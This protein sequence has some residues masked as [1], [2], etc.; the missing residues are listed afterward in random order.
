MAHTK[1]TTKKLTGGKDPRKTPTQQRRDE[2]Q[3]RWDVAPK[4]KDRKDVNE[5][6]THKS[7][8]HKERK[9]IRWT[10]EFS[11]IRFNITQ[12]TVED[13]EIRQQRLLN[14]GSDGMS[15]VLKRKWQKCIT[16]M[17]IN[18]DYYRLH[19]TDLALQNSYEITAI[20]NSRMEQNHM[21]API[22]FW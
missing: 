16:D 5:L 4:F 19:T 10:R 9:V 8:S 15:A 11:F 22:C 12:L 20:H 17:D 1:K 18:L 21:F 14:E 3:D 13:V 2:M 6:F 7:K